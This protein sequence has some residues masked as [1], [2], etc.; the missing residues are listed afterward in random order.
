VLGRDALMPSDPFPQRCHFRLALPLDVGSVAQLRMPQVEA[1]ATITRI[2][3][4]WVDTELTGMQK[5]AP[6][7]SM[8]QLLFALLLL[9]LFEL[10]TSP[11]HLRSKSYS[12]PTMQKT[13][14]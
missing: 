8:A 12:F 13:A 2:N 10:P 5:R 7:V 9:G 3:I 4:D 14:T 6:V 11:C 1:A